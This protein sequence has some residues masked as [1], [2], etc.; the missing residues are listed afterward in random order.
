MFVVYLFDLEKPE[1]LRTRTL[2]LDKV[3]VCLM[4]VMREKIGKIL[5]DFIVLF[6]M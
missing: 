1:F 2:L 6:H 5:V 4:R 3:K